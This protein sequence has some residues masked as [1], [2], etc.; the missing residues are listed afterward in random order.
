M[1]EYVG[2]GGI[3]EIRGLGVREV[4]R[5]IL[6]SSSNLQKSYQVCFVPT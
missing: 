3:I 2:L 4:G 5:G 6:R 1:S